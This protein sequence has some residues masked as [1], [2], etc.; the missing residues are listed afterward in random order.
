MTEG[1][2]PV[3]PRRPASR[4]RAPA[5]ARPPYIHRGGRPTALRPRRGRIH[6]RGLPHVGAVWRGVFAVSMAHGCASH[7]PDVGASP[8]AASTGA[9][10]ERRTH[11]GSLRSPVRRASWAL[12]V[13]PGQAL[14]EHRQ[15]PPGTGGNSPPPTS[16]SGQRDRVASA[17]I[18]RIS[19]KD[20]HRPEDEQG[21]NRRAPWGAVGP[22]PAMH[23]GRWP[24][25]RLALRAP[26]DLPADGGR[27]D[28]R[29]RQ[30]SP[31]I[32]GRWC[33]RRPARL[34]AWQPVDGRWSGPVA[35][36]ARRD[37]WSEV[38]VWLRVRDSSQ[39]RSARCFR[40]W[41]RDCARG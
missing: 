40:F 13:R 12:L 25:G 1:P 19:P 18:P 26:W 34:S 5:R 37:P 20:S 16:A 7:M 28:R 36:W 29:A 10:L 24:G 17:Q 8:M 15:G 22:V 30:A 9:R 23:A 11:H 27:R 2:G 39:W 35:M 31:Q 38:R 32:H 21:G 14:A 33:G 3:G 6:T 4:A 41:R